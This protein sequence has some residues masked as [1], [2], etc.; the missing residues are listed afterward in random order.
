M[1]KISVIIIVKN[2]EKMLPDCLETVSW[3]DEVL[4]VDTGSIDK[5]VEI[6]REFGAKVVSYGKGGNFSA[7][8]S[9]G[10]KEAK[11]EWLFYIDADER[12]TDQLQKE[13]RSIILAGDINFSVYAV[14]RLNVIL[15][16]EMR[17]GGW[18]PD[19]VERLFRKKTLISWHGELHERPEYKGNLGYLKNYLIHNKHETISEM[20]E[21]TNTWS[22]VEAKLMY[23]A[24]HPKMNILRF[25]SAMFREFWMRMIIK[26]A[27]LD[28]AEGVIFAIYQVYSRFISYVKLW[29]MQL[30]S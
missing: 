24:N 13:V 2:E 7:W 11:G 12:V 18:W 8:R 29:E 17:H 23:Q 16:K 10:L 19:Y 20:V 25:S 6:A 5:T 28:G 4:V 27:F 14:P 30:K 1:I 22:Q 15:G 9:K 26:Q 21:K 3:A